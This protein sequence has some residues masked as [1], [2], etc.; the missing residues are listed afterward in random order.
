AAHVSHEDL[1]LAHLEPIEATI[2]LI[3]RKNRL[4]AEDA[5]EFRSQAFIKLIENDYEVLRRFEQRSSLRT[6]LTVVLQRVY[7]DFRNG[8]WGKWRPSAEARRRGAT[9]VALERLVVRDGLMLEEA[10]QVLVISQGVTESPTM[11]R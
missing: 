6:Y 4:R 1:F 2:G 7:L 8:Q 11:L 3:C 5:D 10:I 9:A